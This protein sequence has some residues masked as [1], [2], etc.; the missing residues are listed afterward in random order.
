MANR[1]CPECYSGNTILI[2]SGEEYSEFRSE[3]RWEYNCND[4]GCTF[5]FTTSETSEMKVLKNGINKL[6]GVK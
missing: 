2:Y 4:C 3:R 1:E 6:R 5:C